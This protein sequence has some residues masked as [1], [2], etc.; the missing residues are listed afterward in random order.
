M[1]TE[2][3][4]TEIAVILVIGFLFF[5]SQN[6][7]IAQLKGVSLCDEHDNCII[8]P[9]DYIIIQKISVSKDSQFSGS[10]ILCSEDDICHLYKE[11]TIEEEICT[12]GIHP[13]AHNECYSPDQINGKVAFVMPNILV[14]FL[15]GS[16]IAFILLKGAR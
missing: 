16:I 1:A 8:H 15:F 4:S 10:D 5:F 2:I 6:Y 3:K 13:D 9:D 11:S 14:M 12:Y 7:E